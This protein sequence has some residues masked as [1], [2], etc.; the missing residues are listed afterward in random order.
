MIQVTNLGDRIIFEGHEDTNEKCELTTLLCNSLLNDSNFKCV[1]YES[2]YAEFVK[3]GKADKLKFAPAIWT[4]SFTA[5][6]GLVS[7]Y[8]DTESVTMSVDGTT[9]QQNYR[10]VQITFT[11]S[12][13]Y[14]ISGVTLTDSDNFTYSL[15]DNTLTLTINDDKANS[16]LSQIVTLQLSKTTKFITL[17]N[18]ATFKSKEDELL[19]TKQDTLVSGTNIKTINGETLLG[20]DDMT[21]ATINKNI[22]INSF[23]K[24]NQRLHTIYFG[25]NTYGVDH[26]ELI[27]EDSSLEENDTDSTLWD[28]YTEDIDTAA[29]R[30]L[31]TQK[32][33]NYTFFQ[34]KT[35]TAH[36]DYTGLTEDVAGSTYL[37]INDGVT[38][39]TTTLTSNGSATV[40]ATISS[41]ATQLWFTIG[42]TAGTNVRL[43]LKYAKLELGSVYTGEYYVDMA[44]DI[45][46]C[47]RYFNDVNVLS[48]TNIP[49][50]ASEIRCIVDIPVK[51]YTKPTAELYYG[52]NWP[53]LYSAGSSTAITTNSVSVRSI[54]DNSVIL[55]FGT[56][57]D[58]TLYQQYSFTNAFIY[59]DSEIY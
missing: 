17:D 23:F 27:H 2:G 37:A 44:E 13:G 55:S 29:D 35:V 42:Q 20:S 56:S 15:T 39:T 14:S 10:L 49:S 21:L 19:A 3:I 40:T 51:T 5:V 32:V 16:G 30:N 50:S 25:E 47:K 58:M 8:N 1:K 18:L 28:L 6:E 46:A 24:I 52:S 41:S 59:L 53:Q 38:T 4:L 33:E 54:L 31:L 9:Y 12:S 43:T 22:L 36:L 26:W 45:L 11:L 7:A 57:S 48:R 34:G